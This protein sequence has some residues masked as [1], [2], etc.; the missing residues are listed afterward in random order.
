MLVGSL[1][2]ECEGIKGAGG[3]AEM[4]LGKMQIDSS[5]FE[6]AMTEQ[7]LDRAQ[8][9]AGF[10]K[11]GGEAMSQSVGMNAPVVESGALGGDLAVT[12]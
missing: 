7:Y 9:S 5:Y 8:V 12:P 10:E 6:V 1:W 2:G 3:C 11:V 4:P